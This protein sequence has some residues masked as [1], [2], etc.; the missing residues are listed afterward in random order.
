M[1]RAAAGGFAVLWSQLPSV[2]FP[3]GLVDSGVTQTPQVPDQIKK[4]AS[5]VE[6]FPLLWTPLCELVPTG[7]GPEPPVPCSVMMGK[8]IK[9][10]TYQINSQENSS[11][12]LALS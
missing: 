7:P 8:F 3:T 2:S 1:L 12:M 5:D 11:M 9:K 6:M 4:A 10:E